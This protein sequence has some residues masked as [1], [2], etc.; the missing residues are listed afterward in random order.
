MVFTLTASCAAVF[1]VAVAAWVFISLKRERLVVARD[2]NLSLVDMVTHSAISALAFALY[3]MSMGPQFAVLS[4]RLEILNNPNILPTFVMFV[5]PML[6]Q[7][8]GDTYIK[9]PSRVQEE[10]ASKNE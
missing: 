10:A 6:V 4:S 7:S 9:T 1:V 5:F 2:A 8:L 3:T